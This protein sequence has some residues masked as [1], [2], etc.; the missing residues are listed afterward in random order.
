MTV[1]V[2]VIWLI[3]YCGMATECK[4]PEYH[5]DKK[6]GI[7]LFGHIPISIHRPYQIIR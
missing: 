2:N 7:C 4:L 6:M 1:D 5:N 3:Q